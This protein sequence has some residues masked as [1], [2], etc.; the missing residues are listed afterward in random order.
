MIKSSF[1][2]LEVWVINDSNGK[3]GLEL[4]IKKEPL[5]FKPKKHILYNKKIHLQN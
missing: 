4:R 5:V 1:L 3:I 2:K